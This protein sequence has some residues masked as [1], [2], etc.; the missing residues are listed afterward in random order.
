MSM[1]FKIA[2]VVLFIANIV[3]LSAALKSL[4]TEQKESTGK[5][6]HLLAI[7]VG[8]AAALLVVITI[9][10]ATGNLGVSAPWLSS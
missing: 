10:L 3:A 8:L 4:L 9:G 5:T 1:L 7:R 6:A 2:I